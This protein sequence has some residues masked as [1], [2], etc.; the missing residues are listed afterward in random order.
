MIGI[1]L[2]SHGSLADGLRNAAEMIVGPQENFLTIGMD[3]AADLDVLR[4]EIEAAVDKVGGSAQT[5]VLVDLMGGSPSNASSYLALNGAQVI[6]GINLPMLLEVLVQRERATV[7]ELS[8]L[9]MQAAKE[10][11]INLTRQ[12]SGK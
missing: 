3:P 4:G 10:G 1:V 8:E 11:V 7:Q 9:A 6:C 12:L 5:L 2:V